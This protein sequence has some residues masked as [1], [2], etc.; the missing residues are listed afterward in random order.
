MKNSEANPF[1]VQKPNT[2][3][4][5]LRL[6]VT[7][8]KPRTAAIEYCQRAPYALI[9]SAIFTTIL[10]AHAS[11]LYFD[12]TI[13]QLKVNLVL[14]TLALLFFGMWSFRAGGTYLNAPMLFLSAIYVWHTPL[15]VAHYFA[16]A[17]EFQYMYSVFT[18]GEEFVFKAVALVGLCMALTAYGCYVAYLRERRYA[19]HPNLRK[20]L[21]ERCYSSLGSGTDR[22]ARWMLFGMLLIFGA[23][24]AH[25]GP[26]VLHQGYGII[27]ADPDTSFLATLYNRTQFLWVF[28]IILLIASRRN[29]PK[30]LFGIVFTIVGLCVFLAMFGDR[31][32]PFICLTALIAGIDC[33]VGRVRLVVLAGFLLFL[34]AASY[35]ISVTRNSGLGTHVFDFAQ[36]GKRLD[37]G[38]FL[39]PTGGII[40][41]VMRTMDF[42]QIDGPVYGKTFAAAALS[43]FPTPILNTVGYQE[44]TP[45]SNWLVENSPDLS[46]TH[47]IGFSLVAEAYYNFGMPGCALFALFGFS[48]ASGYFRYI[49]RNDIFIVILTMTVVGLIALNMRNDVIDYF[50]LI[51]YVAVIM[52]YLKSSRRS[53]FELKLRAARSE[54]FRQ[55]RAPR[56]RIN[57]SDPC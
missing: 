22:V 24:L 55:W 21:Q 43:V 5:L 45:P 47:G 49:F 16:L 4:H 29:R 46:P 27:Y 19:M 10:I 36:T 57:V 50:R 42:S 39:Y 17:P 20:P 28:V 6:F 25:A 1:A 12:Q 7:G 32:M 56:R 2:Y 52:A 26:T 51:I 8:V 11:F 30:A 38:D 18:Y 41:D 53:A 3:K 34:S 13:F 31:S 37:L 14:Q 44:P 54:I 40:R 23:Y 9:A 33:L 48:I 15:L 35:V